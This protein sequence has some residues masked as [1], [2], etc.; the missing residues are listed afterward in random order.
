MGWSFSGRC[1]T[2]AN[3]VL[4]AFNLQ[5]PIV[6]GTSAVDLVSSSISGSPPVLSYSVL[7]RQW[8]SNT[9]ASRTGSMTLESCTVTGLDQYDVQSIIFPVVMVFAFLL[10]WNKSAVI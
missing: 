2:D 6:D 9:I 4:N 10:G 7:S 8:S 5:F 3:A 1:Y